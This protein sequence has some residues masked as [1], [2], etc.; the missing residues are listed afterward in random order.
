MASRAVFS[1]TPSISNSTRPGL[2]T[3]TH[4]S[5]A[6]LPLPIRVSAGFLVMGLSGK[7]RIQI[8]P[9]RLMKR[10]IATRE[11]SIC[12]PVIQAGSIAFNPYSPKDI[13]A[14]RVATPLMRPRCCLRYFILFGILYS[15]I[16]TPVVGGRWSVVSNQEGHS[17]HRSLTTDHRL[18]LLWSSR[19]RGPAYSQFVA[20]V[21]PYLDADDAECRV[22]F[23]E[24]IINIGPERVKRQS[25]LQIPLASSY[26]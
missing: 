17:S 4:P 9:P 25:A 10:V 7:T 15:A 12:L 20:T 18:L 11:A 8:F 16:V 21:N 2:T 22:R 14:P 24:A 5:G 19:R 1:S 26:F 6:P 23:R 13:S 3:A